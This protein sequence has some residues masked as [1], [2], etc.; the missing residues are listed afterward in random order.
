MKK[1]CVVFVVAIFLFCAH[2]VGKSQMEHASQAEEK[3]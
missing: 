3:A 1:A 2:K